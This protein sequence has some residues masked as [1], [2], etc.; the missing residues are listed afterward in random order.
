MSTDATRRRSRGMTVASPQLVATFCHSPT[1]LDLHQRALFARA[2]PASDFDALLGTTPVSFRQN[3]ARVFAGALVAGRTG[4]PL[5]FV[6]G[7]R[8][9]EIACSRGMNRIVT[10]STLSHLILRMLQ[11]RD[12]VS[13]SIRPVRQNASRCTLDEV[14]AIVR[15]VPPETPAITIV[16]IAG[17]ACP[18]RLRAGRYLRRATRNA[19]RVYSPREAL[20]AFALPLDPA[21]Q[22]LLRATRLRASEKLR[23][24]LFEGANWTLHVVSEL[25]A[26]LRAPALP[27]EQ[28]LAHRLRGDLTEDGGGASPQTRVTPSPF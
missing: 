23:F 22:H 1:R 5:V 28:R 17:F 11:R 21:Q 14:Q 7:W 12:L 3:V 20:D 13:G 10:G 15:L 2:L 26:W 18:S 19:T 8:C 4:A 16:G 6:E 9:H 25:E 27:L 24:G